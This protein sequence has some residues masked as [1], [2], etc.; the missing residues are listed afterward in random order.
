MNASPPPSVAQ[1]A[2][3]AADPVTTRRF[4]D[5]SLEMSFPAPHSPINKTH[6]LFMCVS[7]EVGRNISERAYRSLKT[8]HPAPRRPLAL[9]PGPIGGPS[10]RFE[11]RPPG[12]RFSTRLIRNARARQALFWTSVRSLRSA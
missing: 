4:V 3:V 2:M 5:I 10:S 1:I 12:Q 8:W 7:P 11:T 9:R 6:I